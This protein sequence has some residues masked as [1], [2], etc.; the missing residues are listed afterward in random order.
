VEVTEQPQKM[1][2]EEE[3]ELLITLAD[4][5]GYSLLR[6]DPDRE[7]ARTFVQ[8]QA[9]RRTPAGHLGVS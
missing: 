3:M 2:Q 8:M 9:C 5:Y 6:I 7:W 1:T 4:R